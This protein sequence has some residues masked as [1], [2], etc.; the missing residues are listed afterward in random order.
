MKDC[1]ETR[2]QDVCAA[3]ELAPNIGVRALLGDEQVALFKVNDSYYAVSAVDP[4]T[5]AAVLARGIVGDLKGKIVVASPI[6]KQH[7]DLSTGECLEDDKVKIK[8]YCVRE[9]QGRVEL[10]VA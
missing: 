9:R 10:A 8:I 5:E 1:N 7:F 4:F 3:E 2:W 6:Y